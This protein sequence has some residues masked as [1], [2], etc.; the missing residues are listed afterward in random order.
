MSQQSIP[1]VLAVFVGTIALGSSLLPVL[2]VS[3]EEKPTKVLP[4]S[5]LV[6]EPPPEASQAAARGKKSFARLAKIDKVAQDLG[7]VSV[8]E[9]ADSNTALGVPFAIDRLRVDLL[10]TFP[11]GG[12]PTSLVVFGEEFIYPVTVSGQVRSSLTVTRMSPDSTWRSTAWGSSHLIRLLDQ[13]RKSV[14]SSSSTF[15]LAIPELNRYFLGNIIGNKF[16]I[17]PL[18]SEPKLG[19]KE[20]VPIAAEMLFIKLVGELPGSTPE[21]HGKP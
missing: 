16:L 20:G 4:S 9:A 19:L 8:A 2:S 15:V 10:R 7:F 18:R 11:P 12:D 21:S 3:A 13:F 5:S 1:A 6:P 17:I 14:D